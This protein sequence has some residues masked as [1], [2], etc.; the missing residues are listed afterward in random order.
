VRG[1]VQ[2]VGFRPTVWRIA[3]SLGLVGGVRNDGDGVLIRVRGGMAEIET[4]CRRLVEEAP[5]LSRIDSIARGA[6]D[7]AATVGDEFVIES[8]A[9]TAVRTGVV[10]DAATCPRCL[11]EV[12]DPEDRRH[13][14]PFTNCTHCGPRL[15]IV[16][17]IPYD[18]ANTSMAVFP[19]C[20]NCTD[21]YDAPSDRRFHAQPN[22][23]PDCGPRVWLEAAGRAS[24]DVDCRPD[25]DPIATASRLLADG[26]ILAIKGVGGVHLACD[27]ADAR[28]VAELRRRKGRYAKPL[29]LMARDLG[30]VRACCELDE[31][32][33]ALM[34]APAA[35]IVLLPMREDHALARGVAPEQR[36]LGVMLPY[37][38]LH[39]LLLSD[40]DRP[41]VMTSGNRSEEPQCIDNDDARAR[42]AEI[43]DALLLHDRDIVNRVD[44]SV[45]R[46][47]DGEPR[48]LRRA[49]GFA[50]APLRLADALRGSPPI[51]AMG[52][53]LKNTFCLLQDGQAV[54]S[55][56]LGDLHDAA[57]A[58]EFERTIDL[59]LDL[60]QHRPA[61]IAVDAHPGYHASRVGREMARS[62]QV[63]VIEVQHH[64]AH[65]A[66]VLADNEVQPGADTVLGIALDGSGFGD[67]GTIWGGEWFV[68]GYTDLRRVAHIGRVPLP[69]GTRA[70]LEPWRMLFAHLDCALG[71]EA[72]Q[73]RYGELPVARGLAE[74]PLGLLHRMAAGGINAPLTSSAGRLF[75]AVAAALGI[76]TGRIAYEGQAAIE[77]ETRCG[78]LAGVAGYPFAFVECDGMRVLDAAPMWRSL[79]DD[80]AAGIGAE[81]ISTRFHAG[82][83]D[84]AI[85][86]SL[87]LADEHA[88]RTVALSGGVF[89]NRVVLERLS[90]GLRAAG[91]GV[92]SHRRVPS[93]DG[94]LSLGQAVCAGLSL[95][96]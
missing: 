80:L 57:T 1:L 44:D 83:V 78:P 91:L 59:Y 41:L 76:C 50:P 2:G 39:H 8:S 42:L 27:A 20:S 13:R 64:R 29:A 23:C 95:G 32:S 89:Q 4:L 77:L 61:A 36:T 67:D 6:A 26:R 69:G 45:A 14:Y 9:D 10:P 11:D 68:G 17:A 62:R 18:R 86:L 33:A 71:W 87:R 30:V 38:P 73:G 54:L 31:Q 74:R 16:R 24:I 84:A 5:P 52:G 75:D 70:I 15:S 7:S 25:E 63:P 93:N 58:R 55:Q 66:A 40:W 3:R 60:H 96:V 88:L 22:A 94:G 48:L 35:P 56:H 85:A 46:V 43:A 92:L 79:L 12:L 28:A 47:M 81:T 82:F 90:A 37:S 65:I 53:E 49:R 19:M 51:L 34:S 72:F 21:E